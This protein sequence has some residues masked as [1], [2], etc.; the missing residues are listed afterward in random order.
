VGSKGWNSSTH[1]LRCSAKPESVDICTASALTANDV[2]LH[3]ARSS[4]AE[5]V[6]LATYIGGQQ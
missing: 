5:R 6:D 2:Y 4:D 3:T 1:R